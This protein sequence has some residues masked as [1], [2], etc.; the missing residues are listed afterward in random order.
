MIHRLKQMAFQAFLT[1][2]RRKLARL[3]VEIHPTSIINKMPDL[4]LAK[5]SR[6]ILHEDVTLTS[7]VR[8]NPLLLHPVMLRTLTPQAVIEFMPH[9]GITGSTI[10]CANRVTIGEYTVIG[11]NTLI[12]D[13]F[14]HTYSEERGWSSSRALTGNPI[15]I[16]KKCFIGVNCI[17]MGGVTIGDNCL[18]SAGTVVTADIPAGHKAFGNPMQI[19]PLPKALGGGGAEFSSASAPGGVSGKL[20]P[21]GFLAAMKD[22]LE[23]DFEMGIDDEFREYEDWDSIAFLSLS[24]CMKEDYGVDFNTEIFNKVA[25]WREVYNLLP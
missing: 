16:G 10:V 1:H 8:H 14:G 20:S 24:T 21:E 9:S 17:V 2:Y 22:A 25:T 3:D 23:F 4:R 18:V 6:L 13:S 11:A 15:T 7:N 19:E 5:G 12:Y